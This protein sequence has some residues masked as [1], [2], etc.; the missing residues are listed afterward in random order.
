MQ[1]L[2]T[3][4]ERA[5]ILV[6]EDEAIIAMDLTR[7]LERLG[8]EIVGIA[9]NRDGAVALVA[10]KNLDLVL[11]DI[12]IQG[13]VDGIETARE[14]SRMSDVPVIF[15]TAYAD[16][17][18]VERAA[19]VA[20]YG[21]L[22]KPFDDGTLATTIKIALTRHRRDQNLRVLRQA[23][24]S[25]P[26]GIVVAQVKGDERPIVL[27]N[28]AFSVIAGMPAERIL[29]NQPC[30]LA[31]DPS[32]ES[33]ARLSD[34]V[35][36]MTT[37]AETVRGCRSTGERFWSRIN[38]A[39]VLGPSMR[40]SHV[41]LVHA[42]ITRERE[43][44]D[45]FAE[46]QKVASLGELSASIAHDFNN[47]LQAIQA[48]ATLARESSTEPAVQDDL[49]EV[50][51][52]A[53]SGTLLTRKLLNYT[54]RKTETDREISD[55]NSVVRQA[56]KTLQLISGR[57]DI[58]FDLSSEPQFIDLDTASVEQVLLN[59]VMNA[60]DAMTEGGTVT[61]STR[62]PGEPSGELMGGAYAQLE[63]RDTGP[64]IEPATAAR[65]FEPFFTTK[66]R[67]RGTGLGLASCRMLAEKVGGSITLRTA[68]GEGSS[69]LVNLPLSK[70]ATAR[71][72]EARSAAPAP[73]VPHQDSPSPSPPREVAPRS[74]RGAAAA[75]S[76]K[77][78]VLLVED[79]E[80]L[81]RGLARAL[82]GH[83]LKV[84]QPGSVVEAREAM[85]INDVA[86]CVLDVDLPDGSGL[87]FLAQLR[88]VDHLMPV[89]VM[90]GGPSV[91]RA[92]QALRGRAA[93]FLSKPI[94]LDNLVEE[95]EQALRE[96]QVARLQQKLLVSRQGSDAM[97]EDLMATQQKFAE[98]I[99]AIHMVFQ[100]IVYAHDSTLYAYEAL[101][102]S[103]GPYSNPR[104]LLAASEI[105]GQVEAL[106]LA[107]RRV[108]A[109][110]IK[111]H[112]ERTEPIFVNLHPME[113]SAEVLTRGDEPLLPFADRIVLEVT[114]RAQLSSSEDL[115]ATVQRLRD[116]GYRIALDD[117]G[118]GYAGLS[119]LVKLAPDIAKIDM[120]LVRNI[121]M[122]GM[123]RELVGLLVSVCRGARTVLVAEGVEVSEEAAMLRDLGCD[124]L[125]GYHFARPSPPFVELPATTP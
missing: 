77:P 48:F 7:R 101:M 50:L 123:K 115:A 79:D 89:I 71:V 16:N 28:K 68:L 11:M 78:T 84:L 51:L 98:S 4:P 54:R 66:P 20:P 52:S 40:A 25:A 70:R 111:E 93:A 74:Q 57:I 26:V 56:R 118:E 47:V 80:K 21:Y 55:L 39:P 119:W 75:E 29:G 97:L 114:E 108:V 30:F 61:I 41:V 72:T 36:N 121:H 58:E 12:S 116:A 124:L 92:Q 32:D 9:D 3:L 45:A 1:A 27:V 49:D 44:Q 43:A 60:R 117:L 110:T 17:T 24:S 35:T 120:S 63:V 109:K 33:V 94:D 86:V 90:T 87:E 76:A 112:P 22:Q 88:K 59:L 15:V 95:V 106:G 67:D 104:D 6:V 53:E 64:G 13:S 83:G 10:D 5:G 38:V 82:D 105:L 23:V 19:E 99:E 34:A 69:F 91:A 46:A 103:R 102:R 42:D 100:P 107:V 2:E 37:C 31:E 65:I 62:R 14:L 122:S 73:A 18:T 125:Q 113:L 8:Y 81:R 96:G 85:R